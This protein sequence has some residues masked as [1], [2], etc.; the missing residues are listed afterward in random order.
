ML[1]SIEDDFFEKNT[2]KKFKPKKNIEFLLS[3]ESLFKGHRRLTFAALSAWVITGSAVRFPQNAISL[4]ILAKI[5]TAEKKATK[6]YEERDLQ[7]D[8]ALSLLVPFELGDEFYKKAY[9]PVG[10]ILM[11]ARS[12]RPDQHGVAIRKV[13]KDLKYIIEMFKIIHFVYE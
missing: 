6:I 10:G 4:K 12:R 9:F 1:F 13:S 3:G 8:A 2:W 5:A 11:I 7:K